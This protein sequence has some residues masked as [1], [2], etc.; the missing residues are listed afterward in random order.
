MT[1]KQD[2]FY[3]RLE[4]ALPQDAKT[5]VVSSLHEKCRE[6]GSNFFNCV[7]SKIMGLPN[8][9]KMQYAEMEKKMT[10]E[11][12]PSCMKQYDLESCLNK[13]DYA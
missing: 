5:L 9:N 1:D 6:V 11:F 7:E 10:N 13:Y 8:D 12:V 3:R 4:H 2:D